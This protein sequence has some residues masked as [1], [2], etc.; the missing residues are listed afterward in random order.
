MGEIK[1]WYDQSNKLGD[2]MTVLESMSEKELGQIAKYL[3]QVVNIY[4]KQSKIEK[5]RDEVLSIGKD[6][7]FGYY[8]A[9]QKRRWYDKNPSLRSALNI[10]STLSTREIDDIIDGF[11]SALKEAGMYHKYHEKEEE[12]EV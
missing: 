1:R 3:Y 12:L 2:M 5:S 4:W 7:L 8:K 11:I 9:Y 6:K 10:M